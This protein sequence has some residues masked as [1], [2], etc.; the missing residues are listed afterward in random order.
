MSGLLKPALLVVAC[1]GIGAYF[2][3]QGPDMATRLTFLAV[4]QGDCAVFQTEGRTVLIDVGPN[5]NGFDAG[6]RIVL[7]S[8][9]RLG[10]KQI[11]LILLIASGFRSYG[12]AW[13]NPYRHEG[14]QDRNFIC[15][16]PTR[17]N[18]CSASCGAVYG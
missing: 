2:G 13:G 5:A 9:R 4:G 15:L 8:L 7:P 11:D 16:C 3:L 18:A 1:A 12:W 17:G 6:K 10:V 14:W